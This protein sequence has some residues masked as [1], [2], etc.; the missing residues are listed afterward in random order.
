MSFS[1]PTYG[2]TKR[3]N[4]RQPSVVIMDD[5]AFADLHWTEQLKIKPL[6]DQK[7]WQRAEGDSDTRLDHWD[8]EEYDDNDK[9]IIQ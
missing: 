8:I 5:T 3:A 7:R 2:T 9:E 1:N 6:R 4:Y